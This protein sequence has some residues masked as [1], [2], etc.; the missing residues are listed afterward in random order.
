MPEKISFRTADVDEARTELT[1]RYPTSSLYVLRRDH[2]FEAAFDE[3]RFES[4]TIGQFSYGADVRLQ[5]AEPGSYHISVPLSG[6]FEWQQT[7]HVPA[8]ATP[9]EAAVFDATADTRIGRWRSDCRA[10]TLMVE[11]NVLRNSLEAMLGRSLTTAPSF[12]P[13]LDVSRG[14]GRRWFELVRW[15]A[16]QS[17]HEDASMWHPMVAAP[18]QEALLG[19][20][21]LTLEHPLREE[22]ELG[23]S[24]ARAPAGA[25]KR[26]IDAIHAHPQE[27]F[28]LTELASIARVSVRR[29]Q[30]AFQVHLGVSPMTYLRNV[31]LARVHEEL[32]NADA[33]ELQVKDVAIRWG[34]SHFGRFAGQYR[35]RFGVTPSQTLKS[36]R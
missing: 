24:G 13:Q 36:P 30:E 34:F 19:G 7:Q 35:S 28:T 25:V 8:V 33:N 22:L 16:E 4:L 9:Q 14:P 27:P 5:C 26:V 17:G 10:L 11:P 1:A 2:A 31:R 3:V 12:A 15:V 18:L 21:L 20:L 29:M 6:T 32:Q 23:R